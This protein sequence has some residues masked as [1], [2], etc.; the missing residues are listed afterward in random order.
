VSSVIWSWIGLH[1]SPFGCRFTTRILFLIMNR[2]AGFSATNAARASSSER[3]IASVSSP[4]T[5][6]S[7]LGG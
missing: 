4:Y 6:L 5:R 2:A 7:G 3:Q 1:H